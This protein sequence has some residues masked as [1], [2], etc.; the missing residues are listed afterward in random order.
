M[1][2]PQTKQTPKGKR[3]VS[4]SKHDE[5]DTALPMEVDQDDDSAQLPA[6]IKVRC[7]RLVACPLDRSS[8]HGV[9]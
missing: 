4:E 7:C 6:A 1:R 5:A 2:S 3:E 9:F 8:V